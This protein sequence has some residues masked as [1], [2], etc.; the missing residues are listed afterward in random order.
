MSAD[1]M[2]YRTSSNKPSGSR[3]TTSA[4]PLPSITS[5]TNNSLI[6]GKVGEEPVVL[7]GWAD[8]SGGDVGTDRESAALQDANNAA[9]MQV[10]MPPLTRSAYLRRTDPI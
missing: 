3:A 6:G 1:L 5:P 4:T 7:G 8:S 9:T 2:T 10:A